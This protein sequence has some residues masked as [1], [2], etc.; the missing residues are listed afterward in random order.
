MTEVPEQMVAPALLVIE[1]AGTTTGFTVNVRLL[2]VAELTEAHGALLVNSQ[3]TTSPVTSAELLYV[4]VFVPTLDP[5]S[6][7]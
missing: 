6:F 4:L 7:H 2:L 1:T 3:V 5:F